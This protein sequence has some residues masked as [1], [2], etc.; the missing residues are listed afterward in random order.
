MLCLMPVSARLAAMVETLE[1]ITETFALL[2]GWEERYA[3]LIELGHELPPMDGQFKSEQNLV[4]GCTS[5]VWL[6]VE[7]K[8]GHLVYTA[9]SDAFIV[10]GLLHIL[11]AAYS[12]KTAAE[13]KAFEIEPVFNELGLAAHLSPNRRNG[14]VAVNG[15]IKQL[16][17]K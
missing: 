12:G 8:D 10:K 1:T 7:E 11:L 4:K 17:E 5:K 9:D 15:R 2:P 3:Y 6:I 14:F 16:A 13:I